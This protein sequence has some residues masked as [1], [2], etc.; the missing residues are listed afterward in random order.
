MRAAS[1]VPFAF[2]VILVT[3]CGSEVS[4]RAGQEEVATRPSTPPE[5]DLTRQAAQVAETGVA[6]GVELSRPEPQPAPPRATRPRP[7][8]KP[9]PAPAPKPDPEPAPAPPPAPAIPAAL[10]TVARAPA[11]PAPEEDAGA[12]GRELPP[13][14]TVMVIPASSG[15]SV[16][17]DDDDSWLTSER[18]R[19]IIGGRGGTCRPRNGGRRIG[20]A[21]R[22]PVGIPAR[23]LR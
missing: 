4:S 12:G 18:P 10:P 22:I 2:T 3:A 17:A 7:K 9:A 8:P 6:S 1:L 21:G 15:P 16:E 23:R 13:G 20:I 19:G 11:Q 5:R 14:K